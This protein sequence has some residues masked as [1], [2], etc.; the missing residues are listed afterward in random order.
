MA[1]IQPFKGWLPKPD[2]VDQVACP[3]YDVM[4]TKEA[5]HL[6]ENKPTSFLHI[7]RPEVDLPDGTPYY[8]DAVYQ[9]GAANLK[10][11]L[12]SDLYAQDEKPAIYIY[13]LED[14]SHTQTGVFT[15]ASVQDYDNDVILKHELTRPDKEND[16]TKHIQTQQAH[17]EPVMLTYKDSE[18]VAFQVEKT[19]ATDPPFIEHTDA[20]GVT[21]KIW[22]QFT[23]VEF[24]KA[25]SKIEK[26]YIADGH[27]RCKSASRVSENLRERDRSFPGEAEY[28]YFPVVL[29]PMSQMRILP[30]N[31][32][33]IHARKN[34]AE[35][36]FNRMSAV[37]KDRK[38]PDKK[39]DICV[40]FKNDWYT[41]T[42]P[43]AKEKSVVSGLDAARLQRFILGPVFDIHD[44][45]TNT[46]I[47]FVGGIRGTDELENRVDSGEADL[48]ISMYPTSI[49]E[50]VDVSDA[51]EL[52][53]PKS[54][55]FEPK[56][57]SG[58]IVHTF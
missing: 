56:L 5:R 40:Y 1:T 4:S 50:L 33:I 57:Q 49:E 16:R 17:A 35:D 58:M 21:H 7:V 39:G 9:K 47:E 24:V 46:N 30:Y 12:S 44:P 23:T 3:P 19:I 53:P 8:D 34:Q 41:I 28:D 27:H 2:Q 55:W 13:Q 20:R 15:C 42:L 54:T 26:F 32:V 52:M 11:L 51:G 22:K 18:D 31:R 10:T 29:F 36:L 43:E 45:R 6:A 25:F 37:K 48:A 38:T 14:D